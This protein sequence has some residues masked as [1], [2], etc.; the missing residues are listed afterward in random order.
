VFWVL[1]IVVLGF[2]FCDLIHDL[3]LNLPELLCQKN[4][5]SFIDIFGSFMTKKWKLPDANRIA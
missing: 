5:G 2:D 3:P 1:E 4:T